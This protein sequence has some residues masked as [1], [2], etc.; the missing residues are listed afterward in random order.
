MFQYK[1]TL[2]RFSV[3]CNKRKKRTFSCLAMLGIVGDALTYY[4]EDYPVRTVSVERPTEYAIEYLIRRT[5]V[6]F[7][8]HY[9]P[10][11]QTGR[12]L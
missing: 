10:I 11:T 1:V 12:G 3:L 4:E 9:S 8:F 5:I 7:S 6:D 2:I